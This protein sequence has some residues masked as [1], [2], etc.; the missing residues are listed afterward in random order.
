MSTMRVQ[1]GGSVWS[2]WREESRVDRESSDKVGGGGWIVENMP[3]SSWR[4]LQRGQR[5]SWVD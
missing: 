2:D 5:L 3:I 4:C 1:K